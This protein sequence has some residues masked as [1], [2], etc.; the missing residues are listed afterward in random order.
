MKVKSLVVLMAI[1]S[2]SLSA[3]A[4]NVSWVSGDL[5]SYSLSAGWVVALYK[6]ADKNGWVGANSVNFA[7][8]STIGDDVFLNVTT[9]LQSGKGGL[10]WGSNFSFPGA[11]FSETDYL[12]SVIFNSTAISSATTYWWTKNATAASA[13]DAAIVNVA[14]VD[15]FRLPSNPLSDA[16]YTTTQVVPEPA[17]ALLLSIGGMGAWMLRRRGQRIAAEAELEG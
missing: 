15:M 12:I 13:G 7:D 3:L 5:S 8:G 4:G 6:D 17:T 9:T 1:A 11:G 14:G 2:L 10:T 16:T